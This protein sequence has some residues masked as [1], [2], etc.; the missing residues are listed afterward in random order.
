MPASGKTRPRGYRRFLTI[1]TGFFGCAKATPGPRV[2]SVDRL[3]NRILS[4]ILN[5]QVRLAFSVGRPGINHAGQHPMIAPG[6]NLKGRSDVPLIL[7]CHIPKTAGITV[8]AGLKRSFELCHIHHY[9]PDP[10]YILTPEVLEDLLEINPALLSISSHHLRSFPLGV[11]GRPTFLVTFLR[12][13]EDVFVSQLRFVQREFSFLSAEIKSAWPRHTPGLPLRELARQYLDGV[14]AFQDYCPQTRFFCNPTAAAKLGFGDGHKYGAASYEMASSILNG[15]HFVGIVEE[16]KKSLEVL[17]DLLLACGIRAYFDLRLKLNSSQAKARP[18][19]LT[20]DD[21]VGRRVLE[22]SASDRLLH[23]EYRV[24]LLKSHC[25][26]R[27]RRW[28]G[29]KPAATDAKQAFGISW[30]TGTRSLAN[31]AQL[32]FSRQTDHTEKP[33]TTPLCSD[34]LE[35]RAAKPVADQMKVPGLVH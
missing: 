29:F 8:S 21:E 22:A 2:L 34:L 4:R 12:R 9:H 33:F 1:S 10:L 18:A 11:G 17:T 7:H 13:P 35:L 6:T 31:S 28:L 5:R 23:E 15:F 20:P 16:M 14:A 3:L 25:D 26:L 32:Y 24:S 27:K 19:W 30:R